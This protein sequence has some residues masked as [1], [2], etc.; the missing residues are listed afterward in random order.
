MSVPGSERGKNFRGDADETPIPSVRCGAAKRGLGK[1]V[2][3]NAEK[4]I[5]VCDIYSIE[6]RALIRKN[7]RLDHVW[8]RMLPL[9]MS[10]AEEGRTE[11]A[12]RW[13][14]FIQGVLWAEGVY[15]IDELKDHNKPKEKQ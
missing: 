7:E 12:F 4:I 10:F 6:L 9:T 14:G 5:E 3:M 2:D 1:V 11:K 13:L 8:N 15:S